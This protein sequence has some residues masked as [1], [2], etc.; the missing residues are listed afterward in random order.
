MLRH[1]IWPALLLLAGCTAL[2]EPYERPKVAAPET[3]TVPAAGVT[4]GAWPDP[5]WWKVFRNEELDKLVAEAQA[6]SFDLKAAGARVAQAKAN[7]QIAAAPLYPGLTIGAAADRAKS[8]SGPGTTL[9]T[10]APRVSYELD[11]WGL[12]RYGAEAADAALLAT[13]YGQDVVRITLTADVAFSYFQI[14]SLNDSLAAAQSSLENSRRVLRLFETQR[15]AGKISRLEVE[16]QLTQVAAIEAGIPPLIRSRKVAYDNLCVLLG[17]APGSLPIPAGSLRRIGAPDVPI[18]VPS[19]LAERRPDIRRAEAD[20]ISANADISAARAA[21]FPTVQLTA[22]GGVAGSSLD[23]L[24]DGPTG[25][26]TLGLNI[27]ATIFDG[28]ALSGQV[29]FTRGRKAELAYNYGQTVVSAFREV[30][31]ALAG[32]EQFAR[33]EDALQEAAVHAREAFRLAE[34]RYKEGAGDFLTVLDAE[35]ALILAE[36]AVD[37]ARFS[38]FTAYV[39]LYR[40]LGGG[41]APEEGAAVPVAKAEPA[42]TQ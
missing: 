32:I 38:R 21:L 15:G 42:G 28:G 41:W 26:Y 40:A 11:I 33:Q 22:R 3:W 25:F 17:R 7:A 35:R 37:P 6:G 10:L 8:Q 23:R 39:D 20:L 2:R 18:G 14:L 29:D 36:N 1:M 34:I 13:V 31:D 9:Y 16:R 30:E 19:E 12:N 5:E 4:A 24:F 27:L